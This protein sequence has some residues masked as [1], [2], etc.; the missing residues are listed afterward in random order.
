[1][2][3]WVALLLIAGILLPPLL[4]V[5]AGAPPGLYVMYDDGTDW[6]EMRPDL[7]PLDAYRWFAWSDVEVAPGVYDGAYVETILEEEAHL[8]VDDGKGGLRQ[9]QVHLMMVFSLS[10]S[11]K[12]AWTSG[13]RQ[14][15]K[16]SGSTMAHRWWWNGM[17]T[18]MS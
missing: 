5:G 1:M 16:S 11:A 7:P 9:K 8:F 17:E 18:S 14:R 6:R 3:R 2:R 13:S 15:S 10:H 12:T 4:V